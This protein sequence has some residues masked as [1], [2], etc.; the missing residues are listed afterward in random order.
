MPPTAPPKVSVIFTAPADPGVAEAVA[1]DASLAV[2]ELQAAG[3]DELLAAASRA[4]VMVTRSFQVIDREVLQAGVRGGHL[5][6]VVQASS[7]LDNIDHEVARELG[8]RVVPVD[9]GNAVA[10][11]ELTVM[12]ILVLHRRAPEHWRRTR[13]GQWP[14]R[15]R[16]D[17]PE[18]RDRRLGIVG[19]GRVGSRVARRAAA[20]EMKVHAVDPFVP[21]ARF[22]AHQ[23]RRVGRL[24]ELLELSDT[25]TLHCPLTA[26]T[27][28]MIGREALA[29]LPDGAFVINTA[30]GGIIDEA[31]LLEALDS[32][33]VAGAALDVF[34]SE[35]P[36]PGSLA[37]HPRVLPTP[38]IGGHTHESHRYRAYNLL[39]ALKAFV[40]EIGEQ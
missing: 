16:V 30:R 20:F 31:A 8:V 1:R 3:R 24:E 5:R 26:E 32:G 25:L 11:A 14:A 10:V 35:P 21:A 4:D 40:E 9:P 29:R 15:D 6:A 23:A 36:G 2:E 27:A 17:D 38:H 34:A 28:G 22:G 7:G 18:V 13:E 33:R 39:E 12:S 19:I 37:T